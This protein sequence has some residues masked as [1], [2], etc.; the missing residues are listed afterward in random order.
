MAMVQKIK[1]VTSL[2]KFKPVIEI[3]GVRDEEKSELFNDYII[4][5]GIAKNFEDIF[6]EMTLCKSEEKRRQGEDINPS[7]IG[8]AFLLR[9]SYGTGK[10]YFLLT[11][12][13]ILEEISKGN[14]DKIKDKFKDFD[15]IVY[16]VDKLIE[17]GKYFVVSINGVSE[18][19][20]DFEDS[21]V[22]NFIQKSKENFP[23][24]DFVSISVFENAVRNLENAKQNP[25]KWDLVFKQL[26]KMDL[27]YDQL[28]SGL[29]KYKRE[30]LKEYQEL[31]EEAYGISINIYDYEFN[32]FIKE[33]KEYIKDKGYKGIVYI[34]D[35][36]SAYLTSII[37]DG[38]INKNLAKIQE[39]AEACHLSNQNDI[40]F[41]A[42]I[43]KSLPI[44]LK[45]VILEKE[46]LDKVVERFKDI[47]INFSEGKNLIKNTINVDKIQYQIMRSEYDEVKYLDEITDGL[48]EHYYPMHPVTIDY[49]IELSNLYAQ[50]N[51]TLFRFISDVVDKKVRL[52][53]V[54][55]DGKLNIITMDYLYDY[56]IETATEDNLPIVT[57]ANVA[58]EF[59][60]EEW[61]VSVIKSLVVSRIKAYDIRGGFDL[62]TGLSVDGLSNYLLI[63]DKKVLRNFLE[64]IANKPNVNIYYDKENDIYLFMENAINKF[65]IENEIESITK[66]LDEYKELLKLLRSMGKNR[67]YY[68]R[69]ISVTPMVGV[70]PVK[71]EFASQ[72]LNYSNLIKT[73]KN[74]KDLSLGNDGDL[75]HLLPQYF[76]EKLINVK[77]IEEYMKEYGTNIVI[78][79]PKNYDFDREIILRYAAY[80][81][82]LNDEKYLDNESD[83]QYLAGEKKKY[84][85]ILLNKIDKYTN[86]KNFFFVFNSGICEFDSYDDLF[87]YMLKKHYPKF[88]DIKSTIG[89]ERG[90]TNKIIKTFI[91]PGEKTMPKDSNPEEDRLIRGMMTFLDLAEIQDIIDGNV[92]AEL[93]T[94]IKEN[95]PISTEIF[96]IVC[97]NEKEEIFD[98]LENTPYGMPEFLIELYIACASSLGKIY[99]YKG[100][101]LLPIVPEVLKG[102]KN[103]Q[104]LEIRKSE[105]DL[106]YNELKYAKDFW[107]IVGK[108][109]KSKKYKKFNPEKGIKDRFGLINDISGD[110]NMFLDK[111]NHDIYMLSEKGFN[112]DLIEK[113]YFELDQLNK[114]LEPEKYIKRICDLPNRVVD[115]TDKDKSLKVLEDLI[116]S[117]IKISDNMKEYLNLISSCE[118]IDERKSRFEDNKKLLKQYREIK[119]LEDEFLD[120]PLNFKKVTKLDKR[121]KDFF[122]MFNTL[123]KTK[124]ED[125]Y[126]KIEE[127][128]STMN[129]KPEVE[130]VE[131]LEEFQFSNITTLK[132]IHKN[133]REICCD[134]KFEDDLYSVLYSCKCM[135]EHSGIDGFEDK[136]Q[137]FM[138][139]VQASEKEVLGVIGSYREAFINLDRKNIEGRKTLREFIGEKDSELLDV[140]MEFMNYL[141]NDPIENRKFIIENS[142]KLAEIIGQYRKYMM[143]V[144]PPA[145]EAK[146]S[147]NDLSKAINKSI[148]FSGKSR[149]NKDEFLDII[150]KTLDEKGGDD[151]I[152][153]FID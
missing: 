136:Y 42:S 90:S 117:F 33:S 146:I 45:S 5:E 103:R 127:I 58:F 118:Y 99:I 52:E 59:C 97:N 84:E 40:V 104:E 41:I 23:E 142:P 57:S 31:M 32:D 11:M 145:Q 141:N 18:T 128:K 36:F 51:R 1:E 9:G 3:N 139:E 71:R 108:Q 109:V 140:Y 85:G 22:K 21:I 65:D 88:P 49:L 25:L 67:Q 115:D 130:L 121:I 147:F 134:N 47:P 144:N 122:G 43:H 112:C 143:I 150:E 74:K 126:K 68:N 7:K 94:P 86:I 87:T 153:S 138:D 129:T 119:V 24:D 101:K 98:I 54:I 27:D 13:T 17:E 116:E 95:N 76:E 79:V 14:G 2:K 111:L 46:E 131:A 20:I 107:K 69:K 60:K 34:F 80:V 120:N 4:T 133:V 29:N 39:L 10:S 35:E 44:L 132:N 92:R 38:R 91:V 12:S 55:V 100:G 135:Y 83:R 125:L 48:L 81:K 63:D 137:E 151:I 152:I 62:G 8:R 53:D 93:K 96:D 6:E 66:G 61:Q 82:I 72:V 105:N 89:N 77:E 102:I 113:I 26:E 149:M 148:R 56:F 106:D 30:S 114:I 75:I 19:N 16:Q 124:H 78:A 28:V 50:E 70:T 73:L 110:I 123:Y 64:N 37:E 15:G